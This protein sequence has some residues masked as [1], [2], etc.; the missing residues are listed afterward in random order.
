[1]VLRSPVPCLIQGAATELGMTES[2]W[3]INF[4]FFFQLKSIGKT[5]FH[6]IALGRKLAW[7]SEPLIVVCTG[8]DLSRTVLGENLQSR[9]KFSMCAPST[10]SRRGC[11]GDQMGLSSPESSRHLLSPSDR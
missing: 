8:K 11:W 1:M 2:D 6:I 9:L 4:R 10:E 5:V 3:L 7:G